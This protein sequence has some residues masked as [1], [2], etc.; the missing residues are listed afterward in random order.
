MQKVRV[1]RSFKRVKIIGAVLV[2]LLV[3]ILGC[4]F[5]RQRAH[6][7]EMKNSEEAITRVMILG[8]DRRADDA[9]RSDTLMV[10]SVRMEQ[11]Q[12]ALMSIPRDTR[13]KIKGHAYD[14][15]NHAYA[16]GGHEL[17][18]ETV[19]ELLGVPIDHYILIDTKAFERIIDTIGGVDIDVEK[20]MYYEDPWDDNGGLIIDLYP[21]EQHLDGDRAIQYV[22]YRDGEGD[23]GRIRR[24]QKFMRAVLAQVISPDILPQ[25]PQL[26]E[27]IRGAVE[28]DMSVSELVKLGSV[29]KEVKEKG[30]D[31]EM[32]PG[33]PAFLSDISYWLPDIVALRHMV[34]E[35]MGAEM[36]EKQLAAAEATAKE[37]QDALPK[38][39]QLA[40]NTEQEPAS[41]PEGTGGEKPDK[42]KDTEKPEKPEKEKKVSKTAEEQEKEQSAAEEKQKQ[43]EADDTPMRPEE[44]SVLVINS[45]GINGAGAEVAGIL[46]RKGFIISSV[47]TGN[48]DS[49]EQTTITT[50][51]R[52]TDVFYGMPFPCIIM[53][54]GGK[55]QAIVNIGRDYRR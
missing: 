29:L 20:R 5:G 11:Q 44:I 9:G 53:D 34:R 38:A 30:L 14:K 54:G 49:R 28:T 15:I 2:V 42:P 7:V 16:Y 48:T 31:A 32:L 26:I 3:A 8:V 13:V 23:I 47:E 41:K 24:Q 55:S 35:D 21:G 45:S 19:Q 40:E 36:T 37:Y 39:I 33:K 10:A 17:S 18:R 51:E 52:N 27:E 25:L 12:A 4:H 50:S 6:E 22:R 43:R 1:K 46:Q